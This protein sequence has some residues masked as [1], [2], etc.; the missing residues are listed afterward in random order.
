MIGRPLVALLPTPFTVST[1]KSPGQTRNAR[2]CFGL[3]TGPPLMTRLNT[4][5]PRHTI[6]NV[7]E[8][9][10][11]NPL[12]GVGL[13]NTQEAVHHPQH[14]EAVALVIRRLQ[15]VIR[16]LPLGFEHLGGIA[17]QL[18][19]RGGLEVERLPAKDGGRRAPCGHHGERD[20]DHKSWHR[21]PPPRYTA[22]VVPEESVSL[23]ERNGE[24]AA[25]DYVCTPLHTE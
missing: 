2:S 6:A 5:P 7:G 9:T 10:A 19:E 17:R 22:R 15:A 21:R 4:W 8:G 3:S 24:K 14:V 16:N 18:E 13:L 1:M 11:G 25:D 12:G 20:E 23:S